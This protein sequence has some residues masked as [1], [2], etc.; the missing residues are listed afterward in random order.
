MRFSRSI[1]VAVFALFVVGI[2]IPQVT[3]AEQLGSIADLT[4]TPS[5]SPS[6]TPTPTA[7]VAATATPVAT[8]TAT[9]VA[10]VA[11]SAS[12]I[13]QLAK[14]AAPSFGVIL[15]TASIAMVGLS[16]VQ[17]LGRRR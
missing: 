4:P 10:T 3:K 6:A 7:T 11:P 17:V 5:P 14:T 15:L 13:T 9:P 1:F 8:A 2:S 16:L 12:P